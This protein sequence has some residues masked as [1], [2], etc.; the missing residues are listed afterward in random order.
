MMTLLSLLG[1]IPTASA[2]MPP[3][4]PCPVILPGCGGVSNVIVTSFIPQIIL[5]LLRAVGAL[6]VV[7][8]VFQGLTLVVNLGDE[9]KIGKARYGILYAILGLSLAVLSQM[10]VA[11]I[12]SE[13]YATNPNDLIVSA[14]TQGVRIM[15]TLT[16]IVFAF[17]LVYYGARM[18]YSQGKSD[19]YNRAKTGI[20]WTIIGAMVVNMAHALIRMV[21]SFFGV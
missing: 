11:F 13:Q 4:P 6:A 7:A 2:Q 16:N 18:V 12:A 17:L 8:V 10:I 20:L 3:L 19:D 15:L 5:F 1:L 9:T 14:L 21:T